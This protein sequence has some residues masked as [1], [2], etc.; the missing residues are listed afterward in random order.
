MEIMSLSGGGQAEAVRQLLA[1]LLDAEDARLSRTE[2]QILKQA[3]QVASV[4]EHRSSFRA[5]DGWCFECAAQ[6]SG[7]F[8]A[9]EEA[10]SDLA[11]DA[12]TLAGGDP[13]AG[14]A[15]AVL[16]ALKKR[17]RFQE[18]LEVWETY[19]KDEYPARSMRAPDADEDGTEGAA[20][21]PDARDQQRYEQEHSDD[22]GTDDD[23]DD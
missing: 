3:Q 11:A 5:W 16:D 10:S 22:S 6:R 17:V 14:L 12:E 18:T 19:H 13:L 23:D 15:E 20:A 21:P 4:C 1:D 2:V 7:S 9:S 8:V